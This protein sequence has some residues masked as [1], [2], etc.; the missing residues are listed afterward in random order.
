MDCVT[1]GPPDNGTAVRVKWPDGIVYGAVFR[2]Q[3]SCMM[4]TVSWLSFCFIITFF[5][6]GDLKLI[7]YISHKKK[8][9]FKFEMCCFFPRQMNSPKKQ[10]ITGACSIAQKFSWVKET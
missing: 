1:E 5:H 10:L 3:S 7:N 8:L 2:G 6:L 4:H 9:Y